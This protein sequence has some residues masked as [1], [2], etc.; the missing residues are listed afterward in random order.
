M[1]THKCFLWRAQSVQR[2]SCGEAEPSARG[3]YVI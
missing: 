2:G 1:T 3:L